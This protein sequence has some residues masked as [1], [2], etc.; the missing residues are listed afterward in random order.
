[1]G[2]TGDKQITAQEL[3]DV[4]SDAA[5]NNP[6]FSPEEANSVI[7]LLRDELFV[8]L[9]LTPDSMVRAPYSR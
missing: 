8:Q 7:E 4:V 5:R 2:A 9:G 6:D 3:F 1:M